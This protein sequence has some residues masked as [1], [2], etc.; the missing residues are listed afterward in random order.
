MESVM[1]AESLETFLLM[2][3]KPQYSVHTLNTGHNR[4]KIRTG[5]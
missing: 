1:F 4:W 2:W 3:P 5:C